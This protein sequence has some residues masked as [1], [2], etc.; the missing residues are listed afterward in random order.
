MLTLAAMEG[1]ARPLPHRGYNFAAAIALAWLI[2]IQSVTGLMA[3]SQPMRLDAFGNPL[4][5]GNK[6]DTN[7]P[8]HGKT[9]PLDCCMLGGCG[10]TFSAAVTPNAAFVAIE[11]TA[12]PAFM[13]REDGAAIDVQ[14]RY[15]P[16][17]PRAPPASI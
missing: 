7:P 5:I 17:Q 8:A 4:C 11:F 2:V 1:R 6:V 10:A 13:G 15:D 14:R 3:A 12:E 16:G 9:S